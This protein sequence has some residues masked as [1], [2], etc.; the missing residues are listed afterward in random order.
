MRIP[1]IPTRLCSHSFYL[2]LLLVGD[3]LLEKGRSEH[4]AKPPNIALGEQ[5]WSANAHSSGGIV[6]EVP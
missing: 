6:P 1:D 3:L 2:S 5:S 4:I